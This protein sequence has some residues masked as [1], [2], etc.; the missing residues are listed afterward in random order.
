M[1]I[2][3]WHNSRCSKSRQTLELLN[4]R[5]FEPNVVEYLKHAP[6]VKEI[7]DVLKKLELKPR[8]IMRKGEVIYK[9]LNLKDVD[10]V[11]ALIEAMFLH[12]ILIERPIVITN[13]KAS[14]GRPPESVLEIL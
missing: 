5:G 12:P 14:I 4:N 9:E 13:D 8:D 6:E 3:I 11:N 2:T 7:K 10:D 1:S